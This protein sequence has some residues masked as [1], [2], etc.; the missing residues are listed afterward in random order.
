[1]LAGNEL[2]EACRENLA[3]QT[4]WLNKR[5]EWHLLGNH[6]LANAKALV[7]S[8]L[9]FDGQE[10]HQWLDQGLDI[11]AREVQEQILPDGG[12]FE[13]SPMYHALALEDL[14]DLINVAHAYSDTLSS[15]QHRDV[16]NWK[17]RIPPMIRWYYSMCHPDGEIAFFNDSAFGAAPTPQELGAYAARLGFGA[18]HEAARLIWLADS[19]YARLSQPRAVLFA[20]MARVGPNYLPGHAHADTLSFEFSLDGQRFFVNSG[21]SVYGL[22]AERHRQRSTAAHNTV[23]VEDRNS[24]DVWSSFRVGRRAHPRNARLIEEGDVLIAEASHDGYRNL[25]GRPLHNRCW[26][27]YPNQLTVEDRITAPVRSAEARYHLHPDV[28]IE[29]GAPNAGICRL[30][31]G[32]IALWKAERGLVRLEPATWHP[33]FGNSLSTNCLVISLSDGRAQFT[34]NWS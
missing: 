13:L 1:M 28:Q 17:S 2:S 10:A 21:T 16:D 8:G 12:H 24:S 4:R 32:Q 22:S 14:L 27:L 29:Q 3:I 34:L 23:V 30:P 9:W 15:K 33:E 19:G 18:E 25:S 20:D 7:F 5:L 11:L 26:R 6:L 31:G